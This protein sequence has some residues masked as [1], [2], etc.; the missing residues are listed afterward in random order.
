MSFSVLQK[1][2]LTYTG[3]TADNTMQDIGMA[4]MQLVSSI[5]GGAGRIDMS[6]TKQGDITLPSHKDIDI[7]EHFFYTQSFS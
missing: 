1:I 3:A 7:E 5:E 6:C 2:W 4:S